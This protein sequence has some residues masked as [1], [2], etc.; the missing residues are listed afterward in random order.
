[1]IRPLA[2]LCFVLATILSISA[3]ETTDFVDLFNGKNLEGWTQR[4]GTATYQI[5]DGAIVGTTAEGSPNSFLCTDKL[6]GDFEMTFEVMLDPGLNS[7]VQIRSQ[8]KDDQPT[9]RVNGPQVEISYDKMAGYIYGEAAGGWMTPDADRVPN[10]HV[11]NGQWNT[12]RIVAKGDRIQTWINGAQVS[13]LKHP[14]RFQSHPKGFIGLQVHGI[15]KGTGPYEVRWR[16]LK[17]REL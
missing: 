14:E 16:H 12:Y 8:C 9:G 13:D 5:E 7:G 2:S 15:R 6:Y 17:I 4:N 11:K 3:A 10:D 1:M